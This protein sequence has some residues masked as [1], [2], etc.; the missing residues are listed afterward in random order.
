MIYPKILKLVLRGSW[1]LSAILWLQ[2]FWW[3]NDF[4]RDTHPFQEIW[5]SWL[6]NRIESSPNI[7]RPFRLRLA[8]FSASD[9]MHECSEKCPTRTSSEPRCWVKAT[10]CLGSCL[11]SLF[12]SRYSSTPECWG[13]KS[14]ATR[15]SSL[16]HEILRIDAWLVLSF[17]LLI[18]RETG[19]PLSGGIKF[20][21]RLRK[22]EKS[23]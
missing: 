13:L 5:R 2:F 21:R 4:V 7:R 18:L 10:S 12:Q 8:K 3:F 6:W 9:G 11:G 22:D 14:Q 23:F 15:A 19:E 17:T 1:E 16:C 20:E